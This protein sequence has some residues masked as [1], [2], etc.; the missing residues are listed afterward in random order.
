MSRYFVGV[1]LGQAADFSTI[2][3]VERAELKGTWDA[4][5]YAWRKV[6]ELRVRRL[7][8]IPLGTPYPEVADRVVRITQ[9]AVLA[10]QCHVIVDGTGVGRP[11]VDLVRLGRP[12][13]ILMPAIVTGGMRQT[14]SNGY[15]YLPKR[16]LIIGLQVMF[17]TGGVRI[18]RGLTEASTLAG[19]LASMQ[20]KVTDEGREQ[21]G[22]WRAGTHDDLVFA[23]ALAC[24]GAGEVYPKARPGQELWWTNRWEAEMAEVFK[25]WFK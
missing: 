5:K 8:R 13:G 7:E 10:G 18:W 4:A 12:A 15:Y 25:K 9:S 17:Q 3:V 21:Y 20:V 1:D 16:D 11:V 24:W 23:V 14:E 2:G 22:A 6:I 19:K